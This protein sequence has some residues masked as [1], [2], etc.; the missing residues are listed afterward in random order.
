MT[1]FRPHDSMSIRPLRP[2]DTGGI[3]ALYAACMA[4]EPNIGPITATGW[5]R[6]I[7]LPQ[8][9]GGRDFLVAQDGDKLVGV[10]ESSFRDQGHRLMRNLKIVVDPAIRRRGL[11]MALLRAVLAQPPADGSLTLQ[12]NVWGD[13][14]AGLGFLQRFGFVQVESEIFMRC[15]AL[16]PTAEAPA[17]LVIRRAA[18]VDPV[19]ACVVEIHNAAY[20]GDAGFARVDVAGMRA[21]LADVQLWLAE[22]GGEILAFAELESD[23]GK[24][25]LESLAGA[26]A[27]QGR[28]VGAALAT[29]AFLT[30]GVAVEGGGEGRPAGLSVSSAYP[31]ALRLYERLGFA[32]GREKG[33]FAASREDLLARLGG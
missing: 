14:T 7:A 20:A 16:R 10:A 2:D 8:F 26:P 32:K 6:T 31:R 28:G 30:D 23:D 29:R 1:T 17:G 3:V 4:T 25:W 27:H 13:W 5:T 15:R 12:A 11:G 21:A 33:K 24:S 9:G 22:R 18:E 19:L